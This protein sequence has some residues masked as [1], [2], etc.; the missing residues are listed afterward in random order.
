ML[1]RLPNEITEVP[2]LLTR[3]TRDVIISSVT[4][5]LISKESTNVLLSTGPAIGTLPMIEIVEESTGIVFNILFHP[6]LAML[7]L[8][9]LG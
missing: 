3:R 2:E 8:A 6:K 9:P 4:V 5:F 7:V 1:G